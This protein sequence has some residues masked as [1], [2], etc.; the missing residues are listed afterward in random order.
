M[1]KIK[2]IIMQHEFLNL[3]DAEKLNKLIENSETFFVG[4]YTNELLETLY[5]G[6][7]PVFS[8]EHRALLYENIKGVLGTF[9]VDSLDKN[10]IKENL[11]KAYNNYKKE[12]KDQKEESS[13]KYKIGYISGVFD[14]CHFGHIKHLSIAKKQ[15]EKLIVGVKSDKFSETYKNKRNIMKEKQRLNII[16]LLKFVDYAV[17]TDELC[18]PSQEIIDKFGKPDVVFVGSDFFRK[19]KMTPERKEYFEEVK[20]RYNC[21]T[22]PRSRESE[23]KISSSVFVKKVKQQKACKYPEKTTS[24]NTLI[25]DDDERDI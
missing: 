9:K 18:E 2:Y 10:V 1:E 22:T 14:L 11:L 16:K 21:S 4:V 20:K 7:S 12:I 17:L 23:A 19:E 15:C 24:I 13:P 8:Y 6:D 3:E 5:P 25:T